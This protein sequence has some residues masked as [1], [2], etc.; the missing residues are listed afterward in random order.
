MLLKS[1]V[2]FLLLFILKESSQVSSDRQCT[3]KAANIIFVMDSSSSIWSVDYTKQLKFVQNLVNNFDIGADDKAVRVGAITFSTKAHLEF[4]IDRYSTSE[5]IQ[6]AVGRIPYRSGV[7]NTAKALELAKS[8][9]EMKKKLYQ[10]PFILVVITDGMSRD[11]VATRNTAKS[12]HKLGVHIYAIGV[13]ASYDV[14]ELKTIASDPIENVYQV[15]NYSALQGIV[16]LF[17]T[18]TCEDINMV[19][20]TTEREA[21]DTTT[22]TVLSATTT[23]KATKLP[24]TTTTTTITAESPSSKVTPEYVNPI[25]GD[26]YIEK[27][28]THTISFGFDII[29][30]GVVDGNTILQFIS[31][32][33][34]LNYYGHFSII[35]EYD[36]TG[37]GNNLKSLNI[38]LM[39]VTNKTILAAENSI[40]W[41]L[42]GLES[43]VHQ[44]ASS[45]YKRNLQN[46]QKGVMGYEVTVLFVD[47]S[48]TILTPELKKEVESLKR[49]GSK[50]FVID[51]GQ[52]NWAK[53]KLL[54][55]LSSQPSEHYVFKVTTYKDLLDKKRLP[56]HKFQADCGC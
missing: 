49:M 5:D 56:P 13:G 6:A 50:V 45:L 42:P 53:P 17:G 44:L 14:E 54:K 7:T 52:S 30:V 18:K 47:S 43:I 24:P 35:S 41:Y 29:S 12:L 39:P 23:T 15:G 55:G 31:S 21:A 34:P 20:A 48:K 1:T 9:I 10:A 40:K 33:L 2:F 4:S 26:Q 28:D 22:T 25:Q 16:K 46:A 3:G 38:P 37:T 8:Q 11:P 32:I 36:C 27:R 51:V 19:L